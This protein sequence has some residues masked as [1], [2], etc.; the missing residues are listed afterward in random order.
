[1]QGAL[2]RLVCLGDLLNVHR[3]DER[4]EYLES[5]SSVHRIRTYSICIRV[6]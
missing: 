4:L 2:R 3:D 1:M 5:L 6:W